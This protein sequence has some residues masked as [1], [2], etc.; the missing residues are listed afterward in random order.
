MSNQVNQVF[1]GEILTRTKIKNNI[2]KMWDLTQAD[3]RHDWYLEAF[4]Y[5]VELSSKTGHTISVSKACGVIAALS[6]LKSWELNK[7]IAKD[8]LETRDCGQMGIF[9]KKALDIMDS[10]GSDESI[11]DILNGRKISAFY[12]NIK[13]PNKANNV[14]IDRHALSVALGYRTTDQDYAGMTANQY[15]FFVQCFILAAVQVNV[16]PLIMQSATWVRFRKIKSQY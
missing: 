11:L 16:S 13:Y 12:L 5:G 14:T 1:K 2:L 3:E 15:E 6:P 7:K 10:D 4:R 9:K 8:M